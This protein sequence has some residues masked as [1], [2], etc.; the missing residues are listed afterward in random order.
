MASLSAV[1]HLRVI[2]P[3]ERRDAVLEVL[4]SEPGATHVVIHVDAAV[5]P[6]GDEITADI[7]RE[8]ANDVVDRLKDLCVQR[9]GAIT[10]DVVDTVVSTAA[11]QAEKDAE[12]DPA[13]AIVWDELA[14]RTRD[15]SR[16]NVTFLAFLCL[17]CLLVAVGV[18]TDSTVTLLGGM[19]VGPE[20]GPLAALAVAAVR[21]RRNMAIRASIALAVGFPLAMLVTGAAVL[22]GEAVGWIP[23][24]TTRQLQEVDYIFRVGPLSLVVALLAGAAG[25]LSLVSSKSAALVGVFI[26]VTTVPAAGFAVVAATVG[27]WDVAA[28]SALQLLLNLVGIVVAGMLVLWLH[29]HLHRRRAAAR[30]AQADPV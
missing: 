18:V 3:A 11:Y 2:S 5:E 1:L 9:D 16:L 27:E 20:F 25:M 30:H 19:V 17:A 28:K 8:C 12:G 7:A 15:E 13:D 14:E 4:R 29:Q 10:L 21:R 22:A 24:E 23:L 6:A 26:S